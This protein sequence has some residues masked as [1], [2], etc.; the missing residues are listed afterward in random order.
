PPF[1]YTTLFRSGSAGAI[2]RWQSNTLSVRPRIALMTGG[3]KVMFG[4]KCPSITSRWIQSAPARAT[5]STS[6][7]SREKS[8]DR[9]DGAISVL[10]V[11]S[12]SHLAPER[13]SGVR[14]F[15]DAG[16]ADPSPVPLLSAAG[17]REPASHPAG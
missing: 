6:A 2:I 8:E 11:I 5:A 3:P 16:R 12:I 17:R 14:Q 1:P 7:P 9:M 4:T 13:I 15:V 10:E